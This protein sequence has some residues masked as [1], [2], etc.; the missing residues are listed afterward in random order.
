MATEL[1]PRFLLDVLVPVTSRVAEGAQLTPAERAELRR[2]AQG[3]DCKG[4]A[5]EAGLAPETVRC[6]RKDIYRKLGAKGAEELLVRMLG[7][8]LEMLART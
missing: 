4:S 7:V 3:L 6:R 1:D 5:Q 2:I 8:A